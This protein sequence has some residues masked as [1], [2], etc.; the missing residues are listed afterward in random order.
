MRNLGILLR[1]SFKCMLG[2]LQGKKARKK[3]GIV[4]SLCVLGY[5]GIAVIFALQIQGLFSVMAEVNLP[6]IPL[7]NSIQVCVLLVFVLAFQSISEKTKT[8]DSD[9]LLSMPIKKT[10]IV[11]SKT[12]SKY[13]FNLVLDSMIVIPTLVLYSIYFGFAVSVVLWGVLLLML[14]PLMGIGINYIINF[15]IVK[16]FNRF[17]YSNLYKTLFALLLFGGFVGIYIYNSAVMGLQDMTT[18]DQFLNSNFFIGWCVRIILENNILCLL[19]VALIVLGVFA[20]G[21]WAYASIFGKTYLKYKDQNTHIKFTNGGCFDG[22]LSKEIK[23]Y[24]ATP[25]LMVNTVIGPIMLVILSIYIVIKGKTIFSVFMLDSKTVFAIILLIFLFMTAMTLI[26]CCMISLEGKYLWILRSTPTSTNKILFSKSILN[27]IIFVP[28]EVITAVIICISL[29]ANVTEW[30]LLITLPIILNAIM[31]FGGTY[32]NVCL[33]KLEWENEA[34]VVKSSLSLIV[35]LLIG[36]VL[37]IVPVIFN[38]CGINLYLCGYITLGVYLMI[39]LAVLVLLF[40]NGKNRF[41]R[42]AC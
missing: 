36:M 35:T 4:I 21:I 11:I 20:L 7:F 31:S 24:F 22:L 37:V 38:L 10:D 39:L 14:F 33:P 18:I 2:A 3:A 26:S 19:W 9:L 28:V 34:Q 16:I 17:K 42:L 1:N 8:N 6:Q 30:A 12:L 40:T 15:L 25:I 41:N 27:M 23:K 5:I 32:I 13:L 29:G